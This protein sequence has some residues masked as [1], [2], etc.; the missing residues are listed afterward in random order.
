MSKRKRNI[1]LSQVFLKDKNIIEK[2]V[3]SIDVKRDEVIVEIGGGEGAITLPL[4]EKEA[5]LIVFEKDDI[6]RKK[7]IETSV[8]R[9]FHDRIL[10]LGDFLKFEFDYFHNLYG[11]EKVKL[12]GNLPYHITGMILRRI[13]EEYGR[14]DSAYIMVQKEVAGRLIARPSTKQYGALTVLTRALFDVSVLFD[15]KPGSFY[16]VPK[17]TSSFVK[18]TPKKVPPEIK[19]HFREFEQIVKKA[20]SSRRKKLKNTLSGSLNITGTEYENRRADELTIEDY[21]SILKFKL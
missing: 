4:L 9:H 1:K 19:G 18:L 12:V 7:L 10:V 13:I 21:L 16:P 3:N 14:I 5:R 6:L 17:V 20:F 2:I 11:L 15:I 8:K